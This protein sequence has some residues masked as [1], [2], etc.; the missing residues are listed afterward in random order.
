MGEI[1]MLIKGDRL[2]VVRGISSGDPTNYLFT[3]Y[4]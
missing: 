3:H 4:L 1:E 2:Q